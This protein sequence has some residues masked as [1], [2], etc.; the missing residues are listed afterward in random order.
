MQ[1]SPFMS[2]TN[3]LNEEELQ[4]QDIES[5]VKDQESSPTEYDIT[6]I[7]ADYTLWGLYDLWKNKEI[8]IPQFQRKY[9]WSIKQ[10]SRLIES[11]MMGL[12]IPP[13][14]FFVQPEDQKNLVIDGM[15]RLH[16]IFY[17]FEGYFGE[18]DQAGKRS[19]FK[20][21]GINEQSRWYGKKFIDFTE[22]DQRKLKNT[23]LRSVLVKQLHPESDL[24]SIY[25]IFE[26]LN[27]GGTSLQDQEIR[28]C[29]YEGHLS[30]LI[31]KL[32]KY[33]NWRKVLG[34]LKFDTR[35]KDEQ[36]ILRYMSLFHNGSAYKKPMKDFLSKFME[37]HRNPVPDFISVEEKRFQDTCD[38]LIQK[39]GER[40]F[41]PK[42]ALNPSIF[43]AIFVAFAKN[44]TKCPSDIKER[45]EKLLTD[46]MFQKYTSDATTDSEI[47]QSRLKL[48]ED[49][50]FR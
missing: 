35:K 42:G 24:T 38:L 4:L 50:L 8:I 26:R 19:E 32:N 40:P 3:Q 31:S 23:V 14:F 12:P 15:Q 39:M 1:V 11:F 9:V 46:T 13:V 6:I 20:L 5:E 41:N 37:T 33:P 49:T 16:S 18:A 10:A 25:H 48:A 44:L 34:K 27:T 36:L 28:D 22:G 17:F 45:F 21:T 7:P 43:D 2:T 47:V 30:E 29:I